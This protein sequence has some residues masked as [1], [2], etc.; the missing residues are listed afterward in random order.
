MLRQLT[1]KREAGRD[2]QA[3]VE[4][5]NADEVSAMARD[6]FA[7]LERFGAELEAMLVG[8]P[9]SPRPP[10][11]PSDPVVQAPT[12]TPRENDDLAALDR[13]LR[14][15]LLLNGIVVRGADI[16]R[17]VAVA[18]GHHVTWIESLQSV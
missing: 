14:E 17:V 16:A 18:T 12:A 3:G 2:A 1:R 13:E 11:M 5:E 8:A 9:S 6:G 10:A 15:L 7:A 4:G